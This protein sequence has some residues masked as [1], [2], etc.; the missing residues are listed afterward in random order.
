MLATA[1]PGDP[2]VCVLCG[3]NVNSHGGAD[4]S[5]PHAWEDMSMWGILWGGVSTGSSDRL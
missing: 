5:R 1:V 2:N 4:I 3:N